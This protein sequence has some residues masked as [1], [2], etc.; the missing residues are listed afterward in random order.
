VLYNYIRELNYKELYKLCLDKEIPI[1][2]IR[3]LK[4]V[5]ELPEAKAM[6]RKFEYNNQNLNTVSSIAFKFIN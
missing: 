2:K 4:E 1:G 3:N 6:V 5:F